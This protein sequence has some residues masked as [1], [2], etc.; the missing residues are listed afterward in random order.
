MK[1]GWTPWTTG[2]LEKL[3][4]LMEA[5]STMWQAA[6]VLDRSYS[7]VKQ[8]L[9]DRSYPV[10]RPQVARAAYYCTY[11]PWTAEQDE[12]LLRLRAQRVPRKDIAA[13]LGRTAAAISNRLAIVAARPQRSARY[14]QLTEHERNIVDAKLNEGLGGRAVAEHLGRHWFVISTHERL[15][16]KA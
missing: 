6:K 1:E 2:E 8:Q 3:R 9:N 13:A 15:R 12:E 5:G 4:Q 11:Q 7:S 16:R 10:Q 14:A